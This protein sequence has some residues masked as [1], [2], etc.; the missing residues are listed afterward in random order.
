MKQ[1]KVKLIGMIIG[2]VSFIAL[3]IGV[4]YAWFIVKSSDINIGAKT[5]KFEILYNN[6]TGAGALI[7]GTLYPS[8]MKENGLKTWVNISKTNESLS[9]N[10][11]L[12]LNI[13]SLT[14]TTD[15]SKLHY[16]VYTSG[17]CSNHLYTTP[18]TCESANQVWIPTVLVGSPGTLQGVTNG[19]TIT[20][21][22]NLALTNTS[23]IYY[24][25]IWLDETAGS[26]YTGTSL[27][28][29]VSASAIQSD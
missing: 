23:T 20:L 28:G 24:I 4:T 3:I 27:S 7:N 10:A 19:S 17:T 1:K 14:T 18:S 2:V 12:T 9:G 26:E 21:A 11:T 13:T 22:S 8:S 5:G 25:Y 15:A 6:D 16:A 29:Y